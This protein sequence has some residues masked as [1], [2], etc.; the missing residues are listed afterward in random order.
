MV[1]P[2]EIL[3]L[4]HKINVIKINGGIL[5]ISSVA[6]VAIMIFSKCF[7]NLFFELGPPV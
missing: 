1:H 5:N 7:G 2:K 3:E 6:I 4:L